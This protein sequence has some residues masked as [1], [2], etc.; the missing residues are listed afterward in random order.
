MTKPTKDNQMKTHKI[1]LGIDVGS[2]TVKAVAMCPNTRKILWQDYQRHESKQAQKVLEYLV[3][4]K[5]LFPKITFDEYKVFMTGSGGMTLAKYVG[6]RFVQEVTAV[7]AAAEELYPDVGTVIDL[8]GQDSKIIV[9]KEDKT[10]DSKKKL[11]SMNDKC[12]GGTGA[13][14]DKIC[15]KLHLSQADLCQIPYKGTRIHSIAGK[16]GVFAETDINGLQKQGVPESELMASLFDAIVS[17]NLTV[18][19]RGNTLRPRVLLLGGPNAYLKGLQEAWQHNIMLMW[20]ERGLLNPDKQISEELI[21]PPENALYYAA[22]GSIFYGLS[23]EEVE[24]EYRGWK[25][26]K[27]FITQNNQQRKTNADIGLA[28]NPQELADFLEHYQPEPFVEKSFSKGELVEGFIGID[29]GS[30]S[31]KAVLMDQDKNVLLK[32]YQLSAGNPIEDTKTVLGKINQKIV[33]ND[34]VLKVNGVVTTGYAKDILGQILHADSTIVETVA[35]TASAIHYYKDVDIICDVGGQDIKIILLK[36]GQVKDFRLNT[37]CS[38]GNGYFLQSTAHDFGLKV[39]DYA[40]TAFSATEA[41]SFGYGCAVFLQSDIVNF[42]RQGWKQSEIL[43]GLAKVLPKNIWLYVAQIPNFTKIGSKFVL[44]GGTQYNLAA[45]KAQVDF[46]KKRYRG[47][48]IEPEI[49]VHK[50]CGESGAIGAAIEAVDLY[51]KG[52]KTR[53]IGMNAVANITYQTRTDESTRCN[54]CK[55]KCLRSFITIQSGN[56]KHETEEFIIG[57]ACEKG[58]VNDVARMK[59]IKKELD[60]QL[61]NVPNLIESSNKEL[62]KPRSLNGAEISEFTGKTKP[63]PNSKVR[64]GIPRTL[65]MYSTAPFFQSYFQGL[66]VKPGNII[67]SDFTT[68]ELYRSGCKRG[69]IDPCYP[70][71]VCLPHVHNLIYKHHTKRPLDMI[72]APMICDISSGL[73][74]TS[75]DW[76]CPAVVAAFEAVKAAFTKESDVFAENN[77]TFY[78]TFLNMAEPRLLE[79]QL[80]KE[81]GGRFNL[82]KKE[83]GQIVDSA[84]SQLD[85]FKEKMQNEGKQILE[86]LSDQNEIGIV[87][88]G[89]PYHLDPGINHQIFTEFQKLGYPILTQDT[90]PRDKATLKE[91]FGEEVHYQIIN[92]PLDISD[93]WKNTLSTNVNNKLWAAKFVAR[94]P[95]LVAIELSSFKCGHDAPTYSVIE[96][97]IETSGTPY[98]SF[99]DVDENKPSG[100]IKLRVET[101][102]YFLKKYARKTLVK[103]QLAEQAAV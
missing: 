19:T 11:P 100:S 3:E 27:R 54:Y 75:G 97:I 57:N 84:W 44:Q 49:H 95:N 30:T 102:D 80:F 53:F 26:L 2:T 22:I 36:N 17:Q 28:E 71:K 1:Y 47:T 103:K 55:N 37:Q 33:S 63:S 20:E 87:L 65:L 85:S 12:A 72:F 18:L 21:H 70:V 88:L 13:V 45:V 42:Q 25:T 73:H 14:I 98:F 31:I 9:F 40:K 99:K 86:R 83:H 62:F 29:A 35:H 38:A 32:A 96:E 52:S 34:A 59:E 58:A 51:K 78:N 77:I 101:I 64:I 16:C 91:I 43:A 93:V 39:E 15:K 8:G 69:A 48:D 46:I 82:S 92:D 4:L 61:R 5:G 6:A 50:F 81:F 67:Y 60:H 68:E 74:N 89:R 7:C 90:L 56:Q 79:N 10:S 24:T 41:P 66:G 23:D 76:V 94:H